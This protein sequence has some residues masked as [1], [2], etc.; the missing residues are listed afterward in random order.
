M[1][2]QTQRLWLM[3]HGE[4][5]PGRP[6]EQRT[7]TPHG[8]QEV[9]KV[10]DWLAA[11]YTAQGW[12][13]PRLLASPFRRAQ[14][15]AAR[16]AQALAVPVETLPLITPDDPP[17]AVVEWLLEQADAP[18]IL[19]SH[20]PLVG[21]LTETLVEGRTARGMGF[22]TA[23]LVELTAPVWASGCAQLQRFVHPG[24]LT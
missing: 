17:E 10:A 23:G 18:L 20:M 5:G 15:S 11:R 13:T 16:L 19:V 4:A 8:E 14:Q 12:P 6:D 24:Q 9:A 1:T 3:R 2:D 22:P 21:A 7:L